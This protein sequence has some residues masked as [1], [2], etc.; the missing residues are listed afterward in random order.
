MK[1]LDSIVKIIV[2]VKMV[3]VNSSLKSFTLLVKVFGL[4]PYKIESEKYCLKYILS[5]PLIL[6]STFLMCVPLIFVVLTVLMEK[7]TFLFE[8]W[9]IIAILGCSL[10]FLQLLYQI[11]KINSVKKFIDSIG[12]YDDKLQQYGIF[13]GYEKERNWI[14]MA[15]YSVLLIPVYIIASVGLII[16]EEKSFTQAEMHLF[17][18]MFHCYQLLMGYFFIIQFYIL[19]MIIAE[20]FHAINKYLRSSVLVSQVCGKL[21]NLHEFMNLHWSLINLIKDFNHTFTSNIAITVV[22]ALSHATL[23]MYCFIYVIYRGKDDDHNDHSIADG[24]WMCVNLLLLVIICK[25]GYSVHEASEIT[26]Y[27]LMESMATA[28]NEKIKEDLKNIHY[29]V[30][31]SKSKIENNFFCVDWRF[32]LSVSYMRMKT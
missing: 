6:Y 32:L 20:R 3:G 23:S 2:P 1:I 10:I 4:F 25:S 8:L 11:R 5:Y 19:T 26:Q 24:T 7:L 27:I 18:H 17:L 16:Y 29:Q 21:L 15:S 14:K 13:I 12:R 28:K 31:S 30:K 9:R 22:N